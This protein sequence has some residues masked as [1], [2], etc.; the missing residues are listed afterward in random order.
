VIVFIGIAFILPSVRT[1]RKTGINPVTFSNKDTAHDYSGFM[2][3]LCTFLLV[4]MVFTFSLSEKAY[5]YFV[6]ISYLENNAVSILGFVV[7]HLA[8]LWI[9][10]AQIHM[11]VSWRIGIDETNKTDLITNGLFS[12]S[13]NP[14][15]LG[16]LV[17]IL[18]LFLAL[19]NALSFALLLAIYIVIQVQVRLEEEFLK[20]TNESG[21]SQYCSNVRRWI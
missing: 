21:Y 5:L 19:P 17:S 4:T 10:I 3:K 18:G 16:I 6:P 1:Y 14:I 20:R 13:R 15:F 11:G 9:I 8:L 12:I 2:M 7:I